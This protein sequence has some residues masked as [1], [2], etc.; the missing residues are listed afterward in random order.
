MPYV[1]RY[2][3]QYAV[4]GRV[5]GSSDGA[6]VWQ[7]VDGNGKDTWD[8]TVQVDGFDRYGARCQR[9]PMTQIIAN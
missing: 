1:A 4:A 8:I 2:E 9:H 7:A 6:A 5:A 3:L